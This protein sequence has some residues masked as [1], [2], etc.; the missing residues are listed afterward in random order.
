[1]TGPAAIRSIAAGLIRTYAAWRCGADRG[2]VCCIGAVKVGIPGRSALQRSGGVHGG[3]WRVIMITR[4]RSERSAG[5]SLS[6]SLVGPDWAS[7]GPGGSE[8]PPAPLLLAEGT[9]LFLFG[10]AALPTPQVRSGGAAGTT[11]WRFGISHAGVACNRHDPAG[12]PK[13]SLPQEVGAGGSYIWFNQRWGM[14]WWGY[15]DNVLDCSSLPRGGYFGIVQPEL[16][17]W[18]VVGMWEWLLQGF[19]VSS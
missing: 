17:A 6:R 1:M 14:P 15:S 4:P 12:L 11:M 13:F 7:D 16:L 9:L 8:D 2:L 10:A 18:E 19:P 3:L 5:L